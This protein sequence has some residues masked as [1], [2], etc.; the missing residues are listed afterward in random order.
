M[1]TFAFLDSI[2]ED[3]VEE[4]WRAIRKISISKIERIIEYISNKEKANTPSDK[5]IS[6]LHGLELLA[7]FISRKKYNTK[8]A[9]Y[10]ASYRQESEVYYYNINYDEEGT[11]VV[12]SYHPSQ[13]LYFDVASFFFNITDIHLAYDK[14]NKRLYPLADKINDSLLNNLRVQTVKHYPQIE[15]YETVPQSSAENEK[16]FIK[17]DIRNGV[18]LFYDVQEI[19]RWFL[20]WCSIR[21]A[22]ILEAFTSHLSTYGMRSDVKLYNYLEHASKF[23]IKTY[24][25][26]GE[27]AY[28]IKYDYITGLKDVFDEQYLLEFEKFVSLRGL[29]AEGGSAETLEE[30]C[31]EILRG[32]KSRYSIAQNIMNSE[33]PLL[34][35][36]NRKDLIDKLEIFRRK[37]GIRTWGKKVFFD[38][39]T[40]ILDDIMKEKSKKK[41]KN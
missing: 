41:R 27:N 22:E 25:N 16:T 10:D 35:D 33:S 3:I 4:N 26:T 23:F 29:E 34:K 11:T 28:N 20:S 12:K 32:G 30:L 39:F 6:W 2:S 1:T 7:L 37:N 17:S 31:N 9:E 40:E 8:K 24:D 36:V 5:Y 13:T 38:C 21:N 14:I 19:H 18:Y 15:G